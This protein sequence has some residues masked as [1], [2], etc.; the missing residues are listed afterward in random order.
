M[1]EPASIS[2]GIAARYAQAVLDLARE[3]GDAGALEADVEA[4]D[5]AIRGSDD[6]RRLL[7]SP[8]ASREEQAAAIGAVAERMG[9]GRVMRSTLA[10]MASKRRLFVVPN[11]LAALRAMMAEGRGEVT[12]EVR[13]ARPLSQAQAERLRAQLKDSTGRDV[14]LDVIVDEGLIGG[15]VVQIGSRMIDTSIRA[16]LNA[17]QNTM[18]EAH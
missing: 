18:K 11:M 13:A 12:A 4:L 17:M 10:L 15:L 8:L 7:V 16:K 6:L 5:A 2:T 3:D 1:S 14:T 9:L